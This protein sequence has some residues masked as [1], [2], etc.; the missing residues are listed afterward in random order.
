MTAAARTPWY[1]APAW[2]GPAW[3]AP[4]SGQR[5]G[6]LGWLADLA[7][8]SARCGG[9]RLAGPRGAHRQAGGR[10]LFG[11]GRAGQA[12]AWDTANA[13]VRSAAEDSPGGSTGRRGAGH[14]AAEPARGGPS[15]PARQPGG[16]APATAGTG[17]RAG[18]SSRAVCAGAG[19]RT[20]FGAVSAP[21]GTRT[22]FGA[23]SAPAGTRTDFGAVSAP[24]GTG[25]GAGAVAGSTVTAGA[26]AIPA[27]AISAMAVLGERGTAVIQGHVRAALP[28]AHDRLRAGRLGRPALDRAVP[29]GALDHAVRQPD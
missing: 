15:F 22:D 11:E 12:L 23:V 1:R 9:W 29:A 18:A 24:A 8:R 21:A 14:L 19:T 17:G 16:A 5:L 26:V 6:T 13:P 4:A 3:V 20:D 27:V 10:C 28:G 25:T 7:G 2:R